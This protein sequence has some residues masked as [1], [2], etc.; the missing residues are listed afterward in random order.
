MAAKVSSNQFC[1]SLAADQHGLTLIELMIAMVI[2][3]IVMAAAL[4]AFFSMQSTSRVID[5]RSGMALNGRNAMYVIEE[6]IRL[7]GFNP[8]GD[9]NPGKIVKKARSWYLRFARNDLKNLSE[10][11]SVYICL[12]R[13][14]DRD[15]NGIADNGASGLV[16]KRTRAADDIAALRFAYAF[17]RDEDGAVEQAG[18]EVI[19][20]VDS[21]DNGE[22][23]ARLVDSD[24]DGKLD[25]FVHDV[26]VSVDKI[27][28]V[29]VW[30]LARSRH[31]AG[32]SSGNRSFWVG[33]VK[34]RPNDGH[35]YMLFSTAFRCRNMF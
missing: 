9:M 27:R 1:I 30:L 23:N 21:N 7:M 3:T 18:N 14:D 2:A 31:P 16:I 26:G 15:E 12:G 33:G 32:R 25:N 19:W 10:E 11:E 35:A 34:Y 24:G 17:D 6:N 28:A 13:A 29:K 5:Q 4:S 20:S 22:L 8:E